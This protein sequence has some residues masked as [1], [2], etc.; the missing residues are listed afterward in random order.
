MHVVTRTKAWNCRIFRSNPPRPIM[1]GTRHFLK[2]RDSHATLAW[3]TWYTTT[4]V[5]IATEPPRGVKARATCDQALLQR[6]C[7]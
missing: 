6:M 4:G 5:L 2:D 1:S 7:E 3:A